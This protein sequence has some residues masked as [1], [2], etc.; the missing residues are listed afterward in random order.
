MRKL[1]WILHGEKDSLN[2]LG[3]MKSVP[4]TV[5]EPSSR[6]RD[7]NLPITSNNQISSSCSPLWK[8]PVQHRGPFSSIYYGTWTDEI[9]PGSH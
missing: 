8:M 4:L 6:Q 1:Q 3:E 9:F 7:W 2:A 5:S